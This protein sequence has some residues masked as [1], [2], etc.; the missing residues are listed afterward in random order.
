V[1]G[2][3]A[4]GEVIVVAS[5]GGGQFT[6]LQMAVNASH[7]GDTLLVR[8]GAYSS[9]TIDGRSLTIAAEDAAIVTVYGTV[10]VRN[11]AAGQSAV[12]SGLV[13]TGA[14][15]TSMADAPGTGL[16]VTGN[17]GAV[18]A[19]GCRFEGALGFGDGWSVDTNDCCT[20]DHHHWGW[21]GAILDANPGGVAFVGCTFVGGRGSDG[22]LYCYCGTGGSGG[23]ALR[24]SGGLLAL[25]DC[26]LTGARGGSNG[27]A[28]GPGGAGARL[29]AAGVT[30][31]FASGSSFQGGNGGDGYDFIFSEGGAGGD[32]IVLGTDA[33]AQILD[34]SMAGGTGGLACG[35]VFPPGPDGVAQSGPGSVFPFAVPKLVLE[36]PRVVRE[37]TEVPLTVRGR[38]GDVVYLFAGTVTPFRATAMWRGVLLARMLHLP[39]TPENVLILGPIPASGELTTSYHLGD[40]PDGVE[41]DDWFLQVYRNSPLDGRALGSFAPITLLDS[42]L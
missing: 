39:G 14:T 18:R 25:Y 35:H 17:A 40:L 20:P 8:Q 11:L 19:K 34:C 15:T 4:R 24:L 6:N 41:A 9:F 21:D 42:S 10:T 36:A 22:L 12:L 7:E 31:L 33:F 3:I 38:P 13:V 29:L 32:G 30:G 16:V 23:D 28:G 26:A 1:I 5:G 2:A 27:Y 37:Q